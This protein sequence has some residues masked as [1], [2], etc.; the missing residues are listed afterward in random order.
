V[1]TLTFC[2]P[3]FFIATTIFFFFFQF[4]DTKHG[5]HQTMASP[6]CMDVSMLL[7]PWASGVCSYDVSLLPSPLPADSGDNLP[8]LGPHL[9]RAFS[10]CFAVDLFLWSD[11]FFFVVLPLIDFSLMFPIPFEQSFVWL[12]EARHLSTLK[13]SQMLPVLLLNQLTTAFGLLFAFYL[14]PPRDP[15]RLFARWVIRR[16]PTGE[17]PRSGCALSSAS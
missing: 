2:T 5:H 6:E 8:L 12:G 9:P 14:L 13:Y 16:V 4:V 10:S 3:N 1:S 7:S 11:G 17:S 15:C